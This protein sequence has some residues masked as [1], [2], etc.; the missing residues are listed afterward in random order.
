MT[1][2]SRTDDTR[3]RNP[4]TTALLILALLCPPTAA[5]VAATYVTDFPLSEDPVSEGGHWIGGR[6][7]GLDWADFR[8]A[9]GTQSGTNPGLYDDAIALLT[10]ASDP[11]QTVEATAK[12][13]KYCRQT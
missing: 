8:S 9:T 2:T 10:G 3:V 7:G 12:T 6:T 11:D 1:D 4:L 13:V 5:V